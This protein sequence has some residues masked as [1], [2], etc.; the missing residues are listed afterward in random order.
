ML[1]LLIFWFIGLRYFRSGFWILRF[2]LL[3]W[4]FLL[5]LVMLIRSWCVVVVCRFVSL[6]YFLLRLLCVVI[7]WEVCGMSIR[8]WVWYMDWLCLLVFSNVF[9]FWSLFIFLVLRLSWVSM[10]RILFL[11]RWL[12]LLERSMLYVLRFWC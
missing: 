3:F 4:I 6:R 8:S 2:I 1:F 5:I 7:L 9:F 11:S 12:R 10:M